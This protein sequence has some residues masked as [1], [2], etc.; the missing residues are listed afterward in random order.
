LREGSLDGRFEGSTLAAVDIR[1][2][3][4]EEGVGDDVGSQLGEE[5]RLLLDSFGGV[6]EGADQRPRPCEVGHPPEDDNNEQA[7]ERP[8]PARPETPDLYM[9]FRHGTL[10][11][12]SEQVDD[13]E[14]RQ[15]EGDDH[16]ADAD[17]HAHD[18]EGLNEG[19]EGVWSWPT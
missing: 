2:A 1:R 16:A 3:D 18:E 10:L 11:C 19:G 5:R 14:H 8:V 12:L 13:V 17:A 4:V 15:V 7:G 9:G 6:P